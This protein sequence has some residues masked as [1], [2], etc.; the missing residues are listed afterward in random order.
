MPKVPTLHPSPARPSVD[1]FFT[2]CLGVTSIRRAIEGGPGH[3]GERVSVGCSN[4]VVQPRP[5]RFGDVLTVDIS[6]PDV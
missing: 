1:K 4:A 6:L 3:E 2:N 5:G